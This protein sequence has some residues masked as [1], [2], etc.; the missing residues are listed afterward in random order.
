MK[1]TNGMDAVLSV[2]KLGNMQ[3]SGA[4]TRLNATE[5]RMLV[6]LS[7]PMS[8]AEAM[9]HLPVSGEQE[10]LVM[11]R[12][13]FERKYIALCERVEDD[14]IDFYS[15]DMALIPGIGEQQ[16][17]S[18]QVDN[19]KAELARRGFYVSIARQAA[20]HVP[21]GDGQAYLVLIIEDDPALANMY[22]KLLSLMQCR[23][24]IAGNRSEIEQAVNH[25]S[26]PDLIVLDLNL[27]DIGGLNVLHWLSS[28]SRLGSTPVIVA[29]AETSKESILRAIALGADGYI[30]K[31]I[32]VDSFTD[33]IRSVLGLPQID[34]RGEGVWS[35]VV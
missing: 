13:L 27:P 10:L 15:A 5:L 23:V 34:R 25:G 17:A 18:A 7:R 21:P 26:K 3:L 8:L 14:A 9:P 32:A 12:A 22:A 20:Q 28:H 4:A 1:T 29:S 16:A 35:G 24:E 33:S 6:L 30:T 2:T 11:A 31:P 19:V